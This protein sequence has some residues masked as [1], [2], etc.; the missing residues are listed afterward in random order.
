MRNATLAHVTLPNLSIRILRDVLT[1]AGMKAE[2]AFALSGLDPSIADC[3]GAVVSAKQELAFQ[4]SFVWLSRGRPDLWVKAARRYTA[5]TLA[6]RGLAMMTAPTLVEW[7]EIVKVVDLYY[8]LFECVPLRSADGLLRGLAFTYDETPS[9][10]A[11]F[12]VYRDVIATVTNLDLMWQGP[13][14]IERIDVVLDDVCADFRA[15]VHGPILCGQQRTQITW[16]PSVSMAPLAFGNELLHRQ[17][18]EQAAAQLDELQLDGGLVEQIVMHLRRSGHEQLDLNRIADLFHMS[19]RTL[20]RRLEDHGVQFRDLKDRAR[21]E[22]AKA[23]LDTTELPVAEIARRLGYAEPASF[24][25]AFKRWADVS[26]SGYREFGS[27]A[28]SPKP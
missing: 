21:Y 27:K 28:T 1:E 9:D 15:A 26:P 23:L 13:F 12:A 19:A 17:Y 5:P 6:V 10:L 22:E 25:V 8:S 18:S 7:F 11:A 14:P 3:P 20:Q 16:H 2:A 4:R 24:S